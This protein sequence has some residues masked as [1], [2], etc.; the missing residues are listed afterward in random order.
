VS[1]FLAL[2]L[3]GGIA[4]YR[5]TQSMLSRGGRELSAFGSVAGPIVSSALFATADIAL[6]RHKGW[7]WALRGGYVVFVGAVVV[8]NG[9]INKSSANLGGQPR[10]Y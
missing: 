6:K 9:R 2:Y 5:S 8:H 1:W 3:F 7:R 4:D 10:A